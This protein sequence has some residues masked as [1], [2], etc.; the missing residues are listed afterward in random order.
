MSMG[1]KLSYTAQEIDNKLKDIENKQDKLDFDS[2]PTEGS[3]NLITSG[4]VYDA[5]QNVGGGSV[6]LVAGNLIEIKDGVISST[7]GKAEFKDTMEI[8][9]NYTMAMEEEVLPGFN[10][11]LLHYLDAD[12]DFVEL[13]Y[14]PFAHGDDITFYVIDGSG[15]EFCLG[16]ET[17]K[18]NETVD[19]IAGDPNTTISA[20]F[21]STSTV[22]ETLTQAVLEPE[23]TSIPYS[24][25]FVAMYN[26]LMSEGNYYTIAIF[27]QND[28]SNCTFRIEKKATIPAATEFLEEPDT[29]ILPSSCIWTLESAYP[30][31]EGDTI[32]VYAIDMNTDGASRYIGSGIIQQNSTLDAT[33]LFRSGSSFTT[34]I[35]STSNIDDTFSRLEL[36]PADPNIP[37]TVNIIY[38]TAYNTWTISALSNYEGTIFGIHVEA[39]VETNIKL[40]NKA[41]SF[42]SEPTL[43]STRLVNSGD[44]YRAIKDATDFEYDYQPMQGSDRLVNSNG[45]YWAI[46]NAT[47]NLQYDIVPTQGSSNLVRSGGIYSAIQNAKPA[48]DP[49]PMMSS[50]NLVTSGG[51]YTAIQNA[52]PNL[53]YDTVPTAGST[54]LVNSGNIYNAL[55][56]VYN[57]TEVYSKTELDVL[58]GDVDTI[59]NQ[60]DI[61]IGE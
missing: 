57:K 42:D 22:T 45:I 14:I 26:L 25:T 3:E 2:V 20:N 33:G 60:L 38:N 28:L 5:L 49:S 11:Y 9:N 41:L 46:Q 31:K 40:P 18:F 54:K 29:S 12:E 24:V 32:H 44:L 34:N 48:V 30:A 51:V 8:P 39:P 7:L 35:N 56:H 27:S 17:I 15:N 61:L 36:T 19:Q 6:N 1:Y 37:Y 52:K 50:T 58:F 47:P 16:T 43:G 21:N 13:E 53:E 55:T 4:G 59:L 23:D 10:L